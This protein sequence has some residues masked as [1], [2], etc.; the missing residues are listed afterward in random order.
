MRHQQEFPKFIK[1]QYPPGTRIRLTKMQDPY[2]DNPFGFQDWD[3]F[4]DGKLTNNGGSLRFRRA[5]VY[6]LQARVTD[7]TGRVFR[8]NSGKVEVL[9]VLSLSFELPANGY[10]D[11]QIEVRTRGN[12]NVLPV[13]W[14]IMKNGTVIP[15]EQA[16]S[17]TLNAQGGK[18]CFSEVGEYRLTATMFDALGRVFSASRQ[19]SIYPL[20]NCSFNMPSTIHTGQNFE[21]ALSSGANLGSKSIVWTAIKDGQSVPVPNSFSGTSTRKRRQI[22]CRF[23][24]QTS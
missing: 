4:I 24:L 20:Y 18:I 1:E 14:I 9:P 15:I 21:V 6:D 19:I 2:V 23:K 17:G 7:S 16:I 5:G 22:L 12:N 10:T 3:T 11:T 8:F 13:E